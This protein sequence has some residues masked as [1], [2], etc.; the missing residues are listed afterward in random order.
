M[1]HQIFKIG[2]IVNLNAEIIIKTFG[3][4]P[5]WLNNNQYVIIDISDDLDPS[6]ET[7]IVFLNR[8]IIPNFGQGNKVS[9]YFI[10]H[11]IKSLRKL[12]LE[13]LNEKR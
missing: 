12:K 13:K 9:T 7:Q 4:T 3:E 5:S 11:S 10:K 2:D 1:K 8:E 6:C